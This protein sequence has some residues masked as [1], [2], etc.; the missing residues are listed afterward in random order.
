MQ[1]DEKM[2]NIG[3][4]M[5]VS[6][7]CLIAFLQ[8]C[9]RVQENNLKSVRRSLETTKQE[10]DIAGTKFS[11]LSSAGLLRASIAEINPKMETVSFSKTIHIDDIPMVE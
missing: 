10:Y 5:V 1:D 6:I 11:A 3:V 9:Y 4:T 2:F 8:V 7:V